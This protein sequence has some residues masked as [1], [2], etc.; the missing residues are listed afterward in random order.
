MPEEF[1]TPV[2]V[3]IFNRPDCTRRLLECL[4]KV[5]PRRLLI[6]ADGP[7]ESRVGEAE[8]CAEARAVFDAIDWECEVST[9]FAATNM[10][11]RQRVASGISWVFETVEEA[12]ILEDDCLPDTSFFW[13]CC[14]ML[15]RYRDDDRVMSVSGDNFLGSPRRNTDSYYFSRL[16]HIWGWATWRRAWKK[17]D[18]SMSDWPRMK[19]EGW[20]FDL[21]GDRP[22]ASY[23][24]RAFD[25]VYQGAIDTWDYQWVYS[26][27]RHG[28]LSIN[29]ATNLVENIGFGAD[30]THTVA[31]SSPFAKEVVPMDF[32]LRHPACIVEDTRADQSVLKR[33][34]PLPRLHPKSVALWLKRRVGLAR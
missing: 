14:E 7:R 28:G 18:L 27:W 10:G 6:V 33:I 19:S 13:F 24:E 15:E 12:I 21:L 31:D 4:R 2:A 29:P 11:C 30:A 22:G 16:V 3:I 8:R 25:Q 34:V 17:Y 9:N 23:F 1:G 32:P 5:E 20:L 26:V